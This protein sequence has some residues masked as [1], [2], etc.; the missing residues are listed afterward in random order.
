[1]PWHWNTS[2]CME[3]SR[4][5]SWMVWYFICKNE[6]S[7]TYLSIFIW[8]FFILENSSKIQSSECYFS[9]MHLVCFAWL[10]LACGPYVIGYQTA[11]LRYGRSNWSHHL[12]KPGERLKESISQRLKFST[13]RWMKRSCSD[14]HT[15]FPVQSETWEHA[16]KPWSIFTFGFLCQIF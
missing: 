4:K 15:E 6:I 13:V 5:E 2:S 3:I 14:A 11:H 7:I 12:W 8:I 9:K 16:D 1:M 10:C